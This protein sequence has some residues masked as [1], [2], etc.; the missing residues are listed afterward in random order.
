MVS[1]PTAG[2]VASY[3]EFFVDLCQTDV[4]QKC[5]L[6][7]NDHAVFGAGEEAGHS[8]GWLGKT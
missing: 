4:R 3:I 6:R 5:V 2:V 1:T 7:R 8:C